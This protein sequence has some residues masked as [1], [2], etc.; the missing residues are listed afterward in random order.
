MVERVR[1]DEAIRD[2]VIDELEWDPA[3]SEPTQIGVA[4][5]NGVVTLTGTTRTYPEKFAAERAA[6]RVFGVKAVA[7][8]IQVKLPTERMRTDTDIAAA[9]VRALEWDT[10]VP[11]ERIK[12]T[13]RDGWVTLEGNVDWRYQRENAEADVR[14]LEGVKGV[15][16][17]ITVAA[18]RVS[19][20]EIKERIQQALR[21][22]AQVDAQRI[23]VETLDGKLILSGTV[24]SWAER[25]EAEAAAWSTR[26]VS[27]VENRI[28]VSPSLQVEGY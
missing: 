4:V 11:H 2:D 20:E 3:I 19:P 28:T 12:V 15:S 8:D 26:G 21:R 5:S 10:T 13:V 14:N 6:R 9:A 7:N 17:Q 23:R 16:N 1:E 24:R 25:E 27:E 22:S 18:P